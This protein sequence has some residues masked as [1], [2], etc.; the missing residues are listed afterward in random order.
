MWTESVL[1]SLTDVFFFAVVAAA[2][3]KFI[4]TTASIEN[5]ASLPLPAVSG[6]G[7]HH[8]LTEKRKRRK[9]KSCLKGYYIFFSWIRSLFIGCLV[10]VYCCW[11]YLIWQWKARNLRVGQQGC[12]LRL[13]YGRIGDIY[14]QLRLI[15]EQLYSSLALEEWNCK[16]HTEVRKKR[17]GGF[18]GFNL[19]VGFL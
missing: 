14:V 8:L 10:E 2:Q 15:E 5:R 4:Q 17:G 18:K 3:K 12:R 11:I 16:A 9:K 13:N 6:C 7:D 19:W 1:H